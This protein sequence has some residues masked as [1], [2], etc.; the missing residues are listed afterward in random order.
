[1][2]F[3]DI[4]I[5]DFIR[6]DKKS[7]ENHINVMKPGPRSHW[8]HEE[9]DCILQVFNIK[10]HDYDT[11]IYFDC[12]RDCGQHLRYT[13]GCKEYEECSVMIKGDMFMFVDSISELVETCAP[14]KEKRY[15]FESDIEVIL[16]QIFKGTLPTYRKKIV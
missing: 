15:S 13:I 4:K 16:E 8:K 7:I 2:I 14:E 6:W 11:T 1:M 9:L 10:Q 12:V 3:N 5:S